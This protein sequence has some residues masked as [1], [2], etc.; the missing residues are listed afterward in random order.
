M[1]RDGACISLWQ[2]I[3]A[4]IAKNTTI[5]DSSFDV[6]IVGGGITGLTT[7]LRLQ[8]AGKKCVIAEAYTIGF[9]TTGGTTAHINTLLDNPYNIIINNFGEDN[10][11]LVLQAAREAVNLIKENIAQEA[12]DC[13][14]E[15]KTAYLFSQDKKQD[16][17]LAKIVQG[18]KTAG[19]SVSYTDK[20]PVPVPFTRIVA[21]PGQAQFHPVKYLYK[22]AEAF[23]KLGGVLLQDCR[24]NG[25]KK[26]DKII[27]DT[28]KGIISA[29]DFIYATHIPL[30][31]N[32]LH[33][34]CAP[35][36]SYAMAVKLKDNNYPDAL[37]YDMEDPYNYYRSQEIDGRTY[38]IAG[39]KDHKT[40]H[41][42]NTENCFR[43]LE[44]EVRDYF[45]VEEIVHKWSS[46]YFEPVDALPY[47]GHLPGEEE[48]VYVATGFGGNGMTYGTVSAIVLSDL[49]VK[50][51][52]VYRKLFDPNRIKPVAGFTNFVKEAAD[53][54]GHL[55]KA[56][57]PKEKLEAAVELAPGEAKVVNYEGHTV[58]AYKD[59]DGKLY[60][61]NSACSH[62][63]CTVAWNNAEKS[64]DCPCHG[65][66]FDINGKV[67]TGPARKDL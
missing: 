19:L 36:R 34:R 42:E 24:V 31:V 64:W 55:V 66:R 26:E 59:T 47:I 18:C 15:E 37:A 2:H 33:F 10:A 57:L 25:Y 52:S 65:S 7:G 13:S 28:T 22:L 62:I 40:A 14:F 12:I 3:P 61:V 39:G 53:V 8:Q 46:Q 30:G 54:V 20:N 9:G 21:I 11:R 5:P 35:Y 43:K 48:N 1:N 60:C 4:Y 38:L 16:E 50:G 45:D 29:T 27:A 56:A 49:I 32:L 17:E 51:D 63:K 41:E 58:A 6:L 44:A 23:E 67:L